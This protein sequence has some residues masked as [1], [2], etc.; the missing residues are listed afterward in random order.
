MTHQFHEATPLAISKVPEG[1]PKLEVFQSLLGGAARGSPPGLDGEVPSLSLEHRGCVA[2]LEA[3]TLVLVLQV[4]LDIEFSVFLQRLGPME[5]AGSLA[6]INGD[7][8]ISRPVDN[9]HRIPIGLRTVSH[10]TFEV[11]LGNSMPSHDVVEVV[12][13]KHLS[14]LVLRLEVAAS[15]GHDAL[16]GSVVHVAGHGGPL[17]DTFDMVGHDPS[18]LEIPAGLHTLNQVDPTTRA[19]LGHLENKNFVRVVTLAWELIPLDVGPVADTS[20]LGDAIHNS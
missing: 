7:L 4:V 12:P 9:P 2:I 6:S 5:V 15:D 13:E 20:K 18:M 3:E 19:D 11:R 1:Q 17:G 10:E 8:R 16:V 14:I